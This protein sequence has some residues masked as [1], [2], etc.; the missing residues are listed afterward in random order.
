[1]V[2]FDTKHHPER[3]LPDGVTECEI[4]LLEGV[5]IE[6][7]D[8]VVDY[9]RWAQLTLLLLVGGFE[10]EVLV[11]LPDGVVISRVF[12]AFRL[13]HLGALEIPNIHVQLIHGVG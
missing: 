8:E 11:L 3:D 2:G 9:P 7:L 12:A 5:L 4:R 13:I 1:M 10:D 6:D